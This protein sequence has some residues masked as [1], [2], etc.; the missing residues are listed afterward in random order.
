MK[1]SKLLKNTS[2][3]IGGQ[4]LSRLLKLGLV[5]FAVKMLAFD[6]YGVF[7]HSLAYFSIFFI[8]AS[9]LHTLAPLHHEL[10]QNREDNKI[11][12]GKHI[13]WRFFLSLGV[14][15]LVV[16][17]GLIFNL[18]TFWIL[19]ILGLSLS[20]EFFRDVF[21]ITLQSHGMMRNESFSLIIQSAVSLLAVI[22]LFLIFPATPVNLAL[23][24]LSGSIVGFLVTLYFYS[25]CISNKEIWQNIK[26]PNLVFIKD[27]LP[28]GVSFGI[29]WAL[30]TS[31]IFQL[32][33]FLLGFFVNDEAVGVTSLLFQ[34]I[35]VALI[36]YMMFGASSLTAV[37]TRSDDNSKK[38]SIASFLSIGLSLVSFYTALVGLVMFV[39]LPMI[40]SDK[41]LAF[42]GFVSKT[43]LFVIHFGSMLVLIFYALLALKAFQKAFIWIVVS[44]LLGISALFLGMFS[45]NLTIFFGGISIFYILISTKLF[46]VT[47]NYFDKKT[48]FNKLRFPILLFILMAL[49]IFALSL[50]GLSPWVVGGILILYLIFFRN[51]KNIVVQNHRE[52]I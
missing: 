14:F 24:Y 18:A 34:I 38:R 8:L 21:G 46:V 1:I 22:L 2:W 35:Q 25:K 50:P 39:G 29:A 17:F 40:F 5:L 20:I 26:W 42:A 47:M 48:F 3:L 31:L 36:P 9:F 49:V 32:A 52:L 7:A 15:L 23:A 13:P 45:M 12:L 16:I 33:I 51:I 27:F 37:H 44:A 11:I 4:V 43:L 10:S 19:I 41:W 30:T 28:V 6:G